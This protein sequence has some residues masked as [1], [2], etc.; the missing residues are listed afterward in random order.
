MHKQPSYFRLRQ[1]MRL[2]KY[3]FSDKENSFYVTDV[4][5]WNQ[6]PRSITHVF[7]SMLKCKL[8]LFMKPANQII[9]R[10]KVVIR[11]K[12]F[13][14]SSTLGFRFSSTL[15]SFEIMLMKAKFSRHHERKYRYVMSIDTKGVAEYHN[16]P[17]TILSNQYI[18]ILCL[19]ICVKLFLLLFKSAQLKNILFS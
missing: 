7:S 12:K 6:L 15:G 5:Y 17:P 10:L 1:N 16:S 18:F 2:E 9:C 19:F 14:F 11:Q 13:R 3:N 4:I 8:L